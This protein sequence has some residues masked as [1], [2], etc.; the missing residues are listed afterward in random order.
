MPAARGCWEG[1]VYRG[2]QKGTRHHTYQELIHF[3]LFSPICLAGLS[4]RVFYCH[5]FSDVWFLLLLCFSLYQL[6][7]DVV[8]TPD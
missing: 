3:E 6:S 2:G 8:S 5:A 1:R 7:W 4:F